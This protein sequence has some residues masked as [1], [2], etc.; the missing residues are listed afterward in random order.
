MFCSRHIQI[1][2][3]SWFLV[4]SVAALVALV[5]VY[6][7]EMC[8]NV[9]NAEECISCNSGLLPAKMTKLQTACVHKDMFDTSFL[10]TYFLAHFSLLASNSVPNCAETRLLYLFHC[11]KYAA[12]MCNVNPHSFQSYACRNMYKPLK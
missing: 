8:F 1:I 3:W 9:P 2:Q 4:I 7:N 10:H 5:A 11:H 6:V 12:L